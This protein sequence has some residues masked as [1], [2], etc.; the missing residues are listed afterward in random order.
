MPLLR[1]VNIALRF[2]VEYKDLIPSS[3]DQAF[4]I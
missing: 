3:G 4:A 2:S 1:E